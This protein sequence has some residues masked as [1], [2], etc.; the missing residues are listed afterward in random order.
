[1]SFQLSSK[2]LLPYKAVTIVAILIKQELLLTSCSS[3]SWETPTVGVCNMSLDPKRLIQLQ[4]VELAQ[5]HQ[6]T[7]LQSDLSIHL[8]L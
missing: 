1:M 6:V 7:S 2:C 4:S 3:N 5:L 8:N